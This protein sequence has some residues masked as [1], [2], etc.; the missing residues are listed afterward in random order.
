MEVKLQ[1]SYTYY[2]VL[3]GVIGIYAAGVDSRG[4]NE[5]IVSVGTLSRNGRLDTLGHF[6]K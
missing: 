6:E 3:I 1:M 4:N 2:L 5:M